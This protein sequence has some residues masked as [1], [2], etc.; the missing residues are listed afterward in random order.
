MNSS[1]TGVLKIFLVILILALVS[2]GLLGVAGV[3]DGEQTKDLITKSST[4]IGGLG[5]ASLLIAMLT[6]SKPD[7]SSEEP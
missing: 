7:G 5:I 4:I 1:V 2:I 3:L 6:A